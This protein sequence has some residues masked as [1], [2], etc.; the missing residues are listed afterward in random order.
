[1]LM[2]RIT[3]KCVAFFIDTNA[4]DKY[5]WGRF[6]PHTLSQIN[7]YN[8][9]KQQAFKHH[10]NGMLTRSWGDVLPVVDKLEDP[11]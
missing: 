8:A 7:I 6:S 1:M 11:K 4:Q 10:V 9:S 3:I 2:S 5:E